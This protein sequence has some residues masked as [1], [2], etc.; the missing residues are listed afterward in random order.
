[1][2]YI[3]IVRSRGGGKRSVVGGI[4]SGRGMFAKLYGIPLCHCVVCRQQQQTGLGSLSILAPFSLTLWVTLLF[5]VAGVAL[6]FW[7]LGAYGR[8][9]RNRQ[10]DKLRESGALSEKAVARAKRGACVF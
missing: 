7:V 2:P 1:V 6:L 5:T 3:S 10:L 9:I 4:E 8:W